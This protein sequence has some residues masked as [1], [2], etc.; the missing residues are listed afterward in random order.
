MWIGIALLLSTGTR[1]PEH[2]VDRSWAVCDVI[3]RP[4][5]SDGPWMRALQVVRKGSKQSYEYVTTRRDARGRFIQVRR[6]EVYHCSS[7]QVKALQKALLA[8]SHAGGYSNSLILLH[9]S[10]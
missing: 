3:D 1:G 10:W 4:L 9:K 7:H 8:D 2:R 5:S 6:M